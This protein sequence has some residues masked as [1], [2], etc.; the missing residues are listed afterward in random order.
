VFKQVLPKRPAEHSKDETKA[1][2][3]MTTE[4]DAETNDGKAAAGENH[5]VFRKMIKSRYPS[6]PEDV[7][8]FLE[9]F[10][11]Y[12]LRGELY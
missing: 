8:E 1:S 7:V 12:F 2:D 11:D 10:K 9:E 3:K 4:T 5:V 6:M